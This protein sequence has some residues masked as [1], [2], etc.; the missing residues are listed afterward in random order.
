MNA[1]CNLV[2]VLFFVAL[3]FPEMLKSLIGKTW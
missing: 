3:F 1:K 2:T